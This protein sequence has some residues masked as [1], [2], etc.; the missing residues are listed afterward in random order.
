[1]RTMKWYLLGSVICWGLLL[2]AVPVHAGGSLAFNE[3]DGQTL[4][5]T[6]FDEQNRPIFRAVFFVETGPLG[7]VPNPVAADAARKAFQSWA[8]VPTAALQIDD[9]DTAAPDVIAPFKKDVTAA[10]FAPVQ[11]DALGDPPTPST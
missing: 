5:W 10:D 2:L 9:L 7:A 8:N 3:A 1:M 6:A 4:R 11:C